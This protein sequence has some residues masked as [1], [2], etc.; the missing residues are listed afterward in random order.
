MLEK[1]DLH[2]DAIIT[3]LHDEYGLAVDKISFL[4]IGADINTAV[5]RA[6]TPAEAVYF[7]KLRS[8]EFEESSVMVPKY[9]SDLGIR[10]IIPP[11]STQTGRLWAS[12]PPFKVIL[13]PYVEGHDG[14]VRKLSEKQWREF[15]A[16]LKR[17]HTT[18]FPPEINK[19]IHRETFSPRWR[20]A[21]R[22]FLE[23]AKTEAFA[24]PVAAETAA[25]LK[26]KGDQTLKIVERAEALARLLREQPSDFIVCHADIHGWNL[27]IDNHEALYMVD[28]DTLIWAP[29]ERDL[30]FI[31]AGLGDSGYTP[32]EEE[33]LFYQG[34]GRPKINQIAIA[35]YRYERIIEDIAAYGERLL[36]SEE[37]GE[38]K[39]QSLQYLKSNFLPKGTIERADQSDGGM[40]KAE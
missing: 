35:Y 14:Y 33:A 16:A 20:H 11:L 17:L 18:E 1:P 15:G 23:R 2:D 40:E 12:L 28:W 22:I 26:T 9:L 21:V 19:R 34:Y 38:D 6:A 25:F 31:G 27:L 10:Q 3:C 5:Y 8:G 36:S 7:V 32:R 13:Y 4:P 29:K 30:M 37:G 24:E 39:K